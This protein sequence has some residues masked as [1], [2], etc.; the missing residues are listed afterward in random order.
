[1]RSL[2]NQG[3]PA[4]LPPPI[5]LSSLQTQIELSMQSPPVKLVVRRALL[6]LSLTL[7]PIVGWATLTTSERAVIANGQLIPEGRRK[8]VN[9]AEAGILRTMLVREGSVVKAGEP[10]LQLDVTQAEASALQAKAAYWGGRARI[11]RLKT[12][13]AE[14]RELD[15]PE[16]VLKAAAADAA[17]QVF[18][19]VERGFFRARWAAFDGQIGVQERAIAQLQEQ[20]AGAQAQREGATRQVQSIREQIIGYNRLLSQGYASRF[21]VLNLQQQ[22]A[23]FVATIGQATAQEA[24]L[25]E[26]IAQAQRQLEGIRLTRLSDIANDLQTTEA[27]TATALQQLRAAQD[28]LT[29]RE[30]LAPEDGKVTNIQAFTPGASIGAGQPILDLVPA[31]DRLVIEAHIMP[32]DIE[33]VVPG[34]RVNIRLLPY[35]MRRVPLLPGSLTIVSPDIQVPAQGQG[36]EPFYLGRAEFDDNAFEHKHDIRTVAGMP[37]EIYILGDK[38]TPLAYLMGPLTRSARRAFVD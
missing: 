24:Q 21:T 26:G 1:M 11:A 15:F 19:D 5:P 32:T 28:I 13:Q 25:R 18:L 33:Q 31:H 30:V 35:R 10:L 8:T 23:S 9:L 27:S 4:A 38:R 2:V 22:E 36:N 16:D 20:V 29:R 3:R 34:Q 14:R 17:I 6:T 37:V 12:E 7:L